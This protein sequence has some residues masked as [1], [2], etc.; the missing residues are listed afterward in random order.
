MDSHITWPYQIADHNCRITMVYNKSLY[1]ASK[2]VYIS[3]LGH[4]L[5]LKFS[6]STQKTSDSD[7]HIFQILYTLVMSEKCD[8]E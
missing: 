1:I 7:K 8:V 2:G 3:G 4:D 5:K 6:M